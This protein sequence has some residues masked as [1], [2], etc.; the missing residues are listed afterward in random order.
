MTTHIDTN[1]IALALRESAATDKCRACGC[2]HAA[3]MEVAEADSGLKQL[4]G[5]LLTGLPKVEINC[6]ECDP[7]PPGELVASINGVVK[8]CDNTCC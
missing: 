8:N 3:L 6:R 5:T 2:L 7:C 4:T 1:P